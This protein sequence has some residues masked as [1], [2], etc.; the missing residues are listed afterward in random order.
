MNLARRATVYLLLTTVVWGSTFPAAKLALDAMTPRVATAERR[1]VPIWLQAARMALA[2][3]LFALLCPRAVRA[4]GRRELRDSFIVAFPGALGLAANSWGLQ[5]ATP[6]VT[7]FLT[8][9]TVVFTPAL[10]LL[11]FG[12]RPGRNLLAGAAVAFAGVVVM[13]GPGGGRFGWP[14]VL[15]LASSALFALQIHFIAK[16][17]RGRDPEAMTLGLLFHMAWLF[18]LPLLLLPEGRALLTWRFFEPLPAGRWID[19]WAVAGSTVYL[20]LFASVL[21]IWVFMRYQREIA[22]TRAAVIYCCEPVF[23]A[24]LAAALLS[25]PMTAPKVA[26][27]ALI[28]AGNLVCE[29]FRPRPR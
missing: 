2:A 13:T 16:Y 27:G 14:E 19:R 12:E 25:E 4:L 1:L 24:A 3:A 22:P 23:A 10:G 26:G 28:L 20:A 17:T 7:A 18:V 8:N 15:I 21:A 9:L 6:T 5:E 29:I 11:F